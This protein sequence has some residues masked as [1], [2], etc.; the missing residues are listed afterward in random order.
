ME[1]GSALNGA[2]GPLPGPGTGEMCVPK[3]SAGC[4]RA[5]P[6]P[7][8]A[9]RLLPAPTQVSTRTREQLLLPPGGQRALCSQEGRG[10]RGDALK[11]LVTVMIFPLPNIRAGNWPGCCSG[12]TTVAGAMRERNRG[13]LAA[14]SS[15]GDPTH[16]APLHQE[17]QEPETCQVLVPGWGCS[18]SSW[19]IEARQYYGTEGAGC[20][21][22]PSHPSPA[23]RSSIS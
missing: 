9:L 4:P 16:A 18:S 22:Q 15:P 23:A 1:L 10:V 8:T 6:I 12:S 20:C 3:R 5:V 14:L 2:M 7:S 17:L 21:H 13:D 11:H 19:C